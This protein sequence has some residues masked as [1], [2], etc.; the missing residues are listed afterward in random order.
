MFVFGNIDSAIVNGETSI[1]FTVWQSFLCA[2]RDTTSFDMQRFSLSSSFV[3]TRKARGAILCLEAWLQ[4]GT[5]RPL[6]AGP[7]ISSG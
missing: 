7:I 4:G 1:P 2:L 5:L 3:S 6:P